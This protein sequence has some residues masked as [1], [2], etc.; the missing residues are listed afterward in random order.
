MA[1]ALREQ[2]HLNPLLRV[3]GPVFDPA[4]LFGDDAAATRRARISI[5]NLISLP[6]QEMQQSFMG[7]LAATLFSW[8]KAH[9]TPPGRALRGLLVIDEAKD[10][11]PSQKSTPSGDA[12]I[13][14]ANQARKYGL[15][16][17]FATQAPKSINHQVIA[18]CATQFYG[19]ASSPEALDVIRE[20]LRVR[21]GGSGDDVA[22]LTTGTF[23]F[24][25]EGRGATK[26]RTRT[27]LS[28]HP[29]NPLDEAGVLERA[30]RSRASLS[31]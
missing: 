29:A 4:M 22:R 25:P 6:T 12:L 23:Y 13:R 18:N 28:H 14:L 2:L 16:L 15:G 21:G 10:F 17:V 1:D 8:I 19:R 3:E 26:I 5:V 30:N 24:C 7:Q 11:V 27:S 31:A 9:P 20:Q